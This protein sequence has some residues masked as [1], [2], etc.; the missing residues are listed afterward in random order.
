MPMIHHPERVCTGCMVGQGRQCRCRTQ[1]PSGPELP[2][3]S[4]THQGSLLGMLMR[5]LQP[6]QLPAVLMDSNRD[7]GAFITH[8]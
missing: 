7:P 8:R 1:A 3:R 2:L 4:N 6:Q 5:A